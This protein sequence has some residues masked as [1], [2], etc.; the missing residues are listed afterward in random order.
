MEYKYLSGTVVR[1]EEAAGVDDDCFIIRLDSTPNLGK[2]EGNTL[3]MFDRLL[4][5][6]V[7][8]FEPGDTVEVLIRKT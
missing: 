4:G 3:F 6:D 1:S 8:P 2:F 5:E 7:F